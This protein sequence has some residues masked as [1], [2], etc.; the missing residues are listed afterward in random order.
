MC[1]C[2]KIVL[3]NDNPPRRAINVPFYV[4]DGGGRVLGLD[5]I[6][7]TDPDVDFDAAQL[8]YEWRGLGNGQVVLTHNRAVPVYLFSQRELA[9]GLVYFK[10]TE[11]AGDAN[12]TIRVSDGV[13]SVSGVLEVR[14]SA[15]FIRTGNGTAVI[16]ERG[17][18]VALTPANLAGMFLFIYIVYQ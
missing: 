13:H 17:R 2:S 3:L 18:R 6:A 16:V 14:A 4:V 7:Y 9:D 10:H 11:G 5:D 12:T 15:P 8:K 1:V